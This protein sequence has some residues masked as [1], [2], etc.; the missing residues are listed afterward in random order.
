MVA[1]RPGG[2]IHTDIVI[3]LKADAE[4]LR[5]SRGASHSLKRINARAVG[6]K[7]PLGGQLLLEGRMC[8]D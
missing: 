5:F 1:S 7:R 8:R 3:H 2:V 4:Q 6:C